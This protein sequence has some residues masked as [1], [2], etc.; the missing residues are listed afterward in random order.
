MK[1]KCKLCSW[2]KEFVNDKPACVHV[3]TS[4]DTALVAFGRH[5]ALAHC[6]GSGCELRQSEIIGDDLRSRT[7]P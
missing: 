7:K 4:R 5:W 3:T 1:I 6:S 2:E